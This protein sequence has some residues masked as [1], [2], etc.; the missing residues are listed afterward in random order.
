V[1]EAPSRILRYQHERVALRFIDLCSRESVLRTGKRLAGLQAYTRLWQR[2]WSY[3]KSTLALTQFLAKAFYQREAQS[4]RAQ[5][6]TASDDPITLATQGF[7]SLAKS[8]LNGKVPQRQCDQITAEEFVCVE[9]LFPPAGPHH[10]PRTLALECEKVA[11][12]ASEILKKDASANANLQGSVLNALLNI[13][14]NAGAGPDG[15][16]GHAIRHMARTCQDDAVALAMAISRCITEAPTE[17]AAGVALE[18]NLMLLNKGTATGPRQM[19]PIAVQCAF[20][21]CVMQGATS[22][23]TDSIREY[24]EREGQWGLSQTHTPVRQTLEAAQQMSSLKQPVAIV[25]LDTKNAHNSGERLFWIRGL[26]KLLEGAKNQGPPR[27]TAVAQAILHSARATAADT[28]VLPI[29]GDG[30]GDNPRCA[31]S[32]Q[33]GGGQG[34]ADLAMAFCGLLSTAVSKAKADTVA[35]LQQHLPD[36]KAHWGGISHRD[37]FTRTIWDL[38]APGRQTTSG[39]HVD[40]YLACPTTD[41]LR[42]IR[43]ILT[44]PPADT[45]PPAAILNVQEAPPAAIVVAQAAQEAPPPVWSVDQAWKRLHDLGFIRV[46]AYQDDVTISG[47]ALL[48]LITSHYLTVAMR[49]L[50]LELNRTK[51]TVIAPPTGSEGSFRYHSGRAWDREIA[52]RLFAPLCFEAVD[53]DTIL[54]FP[55]GFKGKPLGDKIQATI[56]NLAQQIQKLVDSP[57]SVTHPDVALHLARQWVLPR[58]HWLATIWGKELE[59]R[60]WAPLDKATEALLRH[61]IHAHCWQTNPMLRDELELPESRGGLRF[62]VWK[63]YAPY[64]AGESQRAAEERRKRRETGAPPD[65]AHPAPVGRYYEAVAKRILDKLEGL[66]DRD[67]TEHLA[68]INRNCGISAMLTFSPDCRDPDRRHTPSSWAFSCWYAFA[69]LHEPLKSEWPNPQPAA[70]PRE[71]RNRLSPAQVLDPRKGNHYKTRGTAVEKAFGKAVSKNAPRKPCSAIPQPRR[72]TLPDI[73]GEDEN[74]CADWEF[75]WSGDPGKGFVFDV[76]AI[77]TRSEGRTKEYTLTAASAHIRNSPNGP[78]KALDQ[79]AREKLKKYTNLYLHS[80]FSAY[81][82]DLIGTPSPCSRRAL[83]ALCKTAFKGTGLGED[84]LYPLR[85]A[86]AIQKEVAFAAAKATALTIFRNPRIPLDAL[87]SPQHALATDT[88][89]L[90][91]TV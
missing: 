38:L 50:G 18:S 48:A 24:L 37:P 11:T 8:A 58:A 70:M 77:N 40:A 57:S 88:S 79:A 51:C 84:A 54:G 76:T 67:K 55:V 60:F 13:P 30:A 53:V 33:Q 74:A 82:T 56:N 81:A 90:V 41:V 35:F 47:L 65:T 21:R 45:A 39:W 14:H 5:A 66:H 61:C 73:A 23:A 64:A 78:A 10:E 42:R 12:T 75:R 89:N 7:T 34:R 86:N 63:C 3:P 26:G 52:G 91:A 72:E 32:P 59:E 28:G 43:E 85:M 68:R 1:P 80:D 4:D 9:R 46:C 44:P 2:L 22:K 19:R 87:P 31:P 62:P 15:L 83:V 16:K 6:K 17:R 25:T 69:L 29:R 27:E 36:E 71:S 20:A 49:D